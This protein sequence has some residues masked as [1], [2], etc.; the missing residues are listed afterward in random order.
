MPDGARSDASEAKR[1]D[2]AHRAAQLHL[3]TPGGGFFA[4]DILAEDAPEWER[5]LAK[6]LLAGAQLRA[7]RANHGAKDRR[8]GTSLGKYERLMQVLPS[9]RNFEPLRFEGD[10]ET[11]ER[12]EILLIVIAEF[13]RRQPKATG[14]LVKGDTISGQV[15]GIKAIVAEHL[16][17]PILAPTGGKTLA[18]ELQQMRLEDGPS[19]DR[20]L[21]L[22]LRGTHL[23]A[24]ALTSSG[25]DVRS[26]G[27]PTARYALLRT[28]HQ[29]LLR[30]G[31]PGTLPGEPFRPAHGVCWGDFTWH[32]IATGTLLTQ[33]DATTGALHWVLIVRV[34]GIK[35]VMGKHKKVPITIA[36]K[37]PANGASG[38]DVTCTY[39][40]VLRLWEERGGLVPHDARGS[41][42]FFVGPDG[43]TPV[44]TGVALGAITDA[45][46]ALGLNAS[47]FGSSA[48]RRGG[49]TDLR[50]K[51]GSAA[52]KQI[53]VQRGRWC[54]TDIDEIY[55]RS[56]L[57]EHVTASVALSAGGGA[58]SLE[59]VVP[60]WVQPTH[61]GR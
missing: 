11:S 7:A 15:S 10:L 52:G 51:L 26:P 55:S 37:H 20:A 3:V 57:G 24:L 34:R 21:S 46:R 59:Q 41:A 18:R 14:D 23:D 22:P 54:A 33:R 39:F 29:G 61:F 53:I 58:R 49:A 32:D 43:S 42:P 6:S 28:M 17:R 5:E 47:A 35:D 30:G 56:S 12:N 1:S 38:R 8:L 27:W 45:A 4:Q 25:F 44:D 50:D 9:M 36:S 60:G 48:C 2:N 19:A 16:G 13:I 40:A 31:E